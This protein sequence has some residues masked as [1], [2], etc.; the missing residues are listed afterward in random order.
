MRAGHKAHKRVFIQGKMS[1]GHLNP[2]HKRGGVPFAALRAFEA[3]ATL[4]S[5][6]AAGAD[7]GL[8][9]SAISHHVRDLEAMLGKPLFERRHRAVVLTPSGELL[10]DSLRP[11]FTRIVD[12]YRSLLR[13]PLKVR[14]SAA[15]LFANDYLLPHLERLASSLPGVCLQIE[16]SIKALDLEGQD[17]L[18]V[19]RYGPKPMGAVTSRR[20]AASPLIV[21][22]ATALTGSDDLPAVL[23]KGPLLTLS[24]QRNSWHRVFPDMAAQVPQLFFD[25]FEGII[26]A[27]RAGRGVALVPVLAVNKALIAGELHRVGHIEIQSGWDYRLM[28]GKRCTAAAFLAPLAEEIQA[29]VNAE[30]T[31]G[32]R[33]SLGPAH[34]AFVQG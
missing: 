20:I 17:D 15:P 25:S 18:I 16:S 31:R 34:N 3:A 5:F 33:H 28:A 22:G 23:A 9:A 32:S 4:G 14:L 29:I 13:Q 1:S 8:T 2:D 6:K 19:L 7:L 12:G 10:A 21:V 11:A 26:Q 24:S 30:H 27:A